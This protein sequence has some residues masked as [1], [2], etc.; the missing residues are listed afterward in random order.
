ML[1]NLNLDPVFVEN[2][3]STVKTLTIVLVL[4][5]TL[6]LFTS[7]RNHIATQENII[8]A[9]INVIVGQPS[10]TINNPIGTN[11]AVCQNA[12]SA[13]ISANSTGLL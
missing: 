1:A 5:V 9:A 11:S 2:A 7:L 8:P 3:R 10:W 4:L 12:I 13:I 6:S